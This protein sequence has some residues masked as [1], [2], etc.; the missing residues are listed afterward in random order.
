MLIFRRVLNQWTDRL[1]FYNDSDLNWWRGAVSWKTG[2][3]PTRSTA[4][5]RVCICFEWISYAFAE[6]HIEKISYARTVNQ[7]VLYSSKLENA[8][9]ELCATKTARRIG[10]HWCWATI[11]RHYWVPSWST[12]GINRKRSCANFFCKLYKR[13]NATQPRWGDGLLLGS[14]GR[15]ER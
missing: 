12:S 10:Y 9:L 3:P 7:F 5:G 13:Y 6:P 8:R 1:L 11:Y 15:I 4:Q 2:G 14:S